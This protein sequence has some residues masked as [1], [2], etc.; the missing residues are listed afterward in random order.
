MDSL[1]VLYDHYKDTFDIIRHLESKRNKL[2]VITGIIISLFFIVIVQP[3]QS[4]PTITG[5]I[6]QYTKV[7]VLFQFSTIQS[8]LWVILLYVLSYYYKSCID[9]E[10]RYPYLHNL[11]T[12]IEYKI[13]APFSRE[14]KSYLEK[15]PLL[16]NII[17]YLFIYFFPILY[18]SCIIIKIVSEFKTS[19][20]Y[21]NFDTVIA[22]L[23][24]ILI[25]VFLFKDVHFRKS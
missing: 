7:K 20:Y 9:I 18:L 2:F 4:I 25:I 3:Q 5:F 10:R 23:C 1:S 12:I 6:Q 21:T 13:D 22:I 8:I 11:E 17:Y 19:G 14:G 15:Y 24:S 16:N